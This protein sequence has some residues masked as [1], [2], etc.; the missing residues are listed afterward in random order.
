VCGARGSEAQRAEAAACHQ[1]R[2][3]PGGEKIGLNTGGF[4]EFMVNTGGLSNLFMIPGV[5][6]GIKN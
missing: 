5:Y 4:S 6:L 1:G 2:S 3:T